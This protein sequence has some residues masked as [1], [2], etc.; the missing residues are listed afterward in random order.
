MLQR[1]LQSILI[2]WAF[3]IY[4]QMGWVEVLSV[5]SKLCV[6]LLERGGGGVAQVGL[7][8]PPPVVTYDTAP[9]LAVKE[10]GQ[11]DTQ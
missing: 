7:H 3:I 10:M 8:N 6:A 1:L 4:L 9:P 11:R 2:R 5:C